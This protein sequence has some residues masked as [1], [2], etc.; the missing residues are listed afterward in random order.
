[1]S[2]FIGGS[3]WAMAR[4]IGKGNILVTTRTVAR[5]NRAELDLLYFEL[6]RYLR[7]LRGEQ[8]DLAD[9]LAV[10]S[11]NQMLVRLRRAQT[12]VQAQRTGG[13]APG[14]RGRPDG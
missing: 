10:R 11:R 6:E 1:M 9:T 14:A 8:P 3:A 13:A 5:L 7:Q 4:D 2:G 12:L